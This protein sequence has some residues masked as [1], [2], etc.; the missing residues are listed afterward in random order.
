LNHLKD[1]FISLQNNQEISNSV[2]YDDTVYNDSRA[3]LEIAL[4]DLEKANTK[5]MQATKE[6]LY[7]KEN[8][9]VA[10]DQSLVDEFQKKMLEMQNEHENHLK[11]MEMKFA[12][13][14]EKS[15]SEALEFDN[16]LNSLKRE[17]NTKVFL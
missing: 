15:K 5:L 17:I 13:L 7:L 10:Q 9:K 14:V 2:I 3:D 6:N 1:Q 12:S 16:K 11:Q 8:L 4:L